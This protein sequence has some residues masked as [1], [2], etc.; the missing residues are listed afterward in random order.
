MENTKKKENKFVIKDT[1]N[2]LKV[3]LYTYEILS[4]SNEIK[5]T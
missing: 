5:I 1:L 3:L 2:S 4:L